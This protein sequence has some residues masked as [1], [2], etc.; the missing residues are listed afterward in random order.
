[1]PLVIPIPDVDVGAAGEG[2]EYILSDEDWHV[3]AYYE[4]TPPKVAALAEDVGWC[5]HYYKKAECS[6]F[7]HGS[8][9]SFCGRGAGNGCR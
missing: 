8:V 3:T 5:S 1:M 2:D 7:C 6:M 9:D 4:N